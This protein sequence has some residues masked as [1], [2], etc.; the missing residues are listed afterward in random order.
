MR[1][2]SFIAGFVSATT[3]GPARAQQARRPESAKKVGVLMGGADDSYEQSNMAAF[4]G[5]LRELGW[6]I[7]ASLLVEVRWGSGDADRMRMNA[8]E[9]VRMNPDVI[10]A[11]G[12]D[13]PSAAAATKTVPIVF[14]LTSDAVAP[15][16]V[17]TFARPDGNLTGFTSYEL[18]LVGKRLELLKEIAPH[19]QRVTFIHS[20]WNPS[21]KAQFQHLVQASP[22]FAVNVTDG[23][24]ENGNELEQVVMLCA[25]KP[26]SGL[27]VAFDAFTTVHREQIIQLA[28][29]NRLPAVYPFDFFAQKGG[30][31][32]YGLDQRDQ[33]RRAASYVDRL[34]RGARVS[35][36]PVQAAT[37][38][39]L[40]VNVK[41]AKA[42]G[43]TVPASLLAQADE[44]IE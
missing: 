9:L 21:T 36:L 32:S 18:S 2:R 15:G 33:F 1:R 31:L 4:D 20:T 37:K 11:T 28:N 30:L 7:G 13:V 42:L 29:R 24:A 16:Y 17:K 41:T 25:R 40:I 43:L 5:A 35:D 12:A 38:F 23:P 39:S 44:V 34:L 22:S 6:R 14:V 8:K 19:I 10:L 27:V 26:H 3:I